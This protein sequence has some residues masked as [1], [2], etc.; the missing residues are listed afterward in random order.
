MV[1]CSGWQPDRQYDFWIHQQ[2]GLNLHSHGGIESPIT[3]QQEVTCFGD[4]N[5]ENNWILQR[6]SK[7]S[8][9]D[10]SGYWAVEVTCHADGHEEN[11][12]WVV[13]ILE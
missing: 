1:F 11:H 13:E 5:E 7:T 8:I 4:S 6:Y 3:R 12:K 9:Y 10:N 2:T